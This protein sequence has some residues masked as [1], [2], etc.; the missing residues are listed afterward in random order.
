MEVMSFVFT[1]I[2]VYYFNYEKSSDEILLVP[3]I[4]VDDIFLALND[5]EYV[6]TIKSGFQNYLI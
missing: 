5:L 6:K 2:D 3:F 1:M 4:Y